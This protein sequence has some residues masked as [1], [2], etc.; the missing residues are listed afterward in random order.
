MNETEK[1]YLNNRAKNVIRAFWG[2]FAIHIAVF[3]SLL[4]IVKSTP[5]DFSLTFS[6]S[7][8][9]TILSVFYL[10]VLIGLPFNF[11]YFHKKTQ[12]T[13][14][15]NNVSEKIKKYRNC[16]ALRIYIN[17]ILAT[18]GSVI[19]AVVTE[20]KSVLYC[21]IMIDIAMIFCYVNKNNFINDL[22]LDTNEEK[23]KQI[24]ENTIL[25]NKI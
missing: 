9:D 12:K 20:S 7:T 2:L 3:A 18:I 16:A 10:I 5:L 23:E 24:T 6:A 1:N 11:Y 8:S 4:I 19:Y 14:L 21:I 25:N 17:F 15:L 22:K 13:A